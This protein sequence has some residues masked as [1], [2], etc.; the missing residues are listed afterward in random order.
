[1]HI[2]IRNILNNKIKILLKKILTRVQIEEKK[3]MLVETRKRGFYENQEVLGEKKSNAS[4][5]SEKK[6][7]LKSHK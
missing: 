7:M 3:K 1:M 6:N 2:L 5:H 4:F